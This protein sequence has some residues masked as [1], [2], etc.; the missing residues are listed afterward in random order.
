MR[1][2]PGR[3]DLHILK[4]TNA[5]I[6]QY[7]QVPLILFYCLLT[8]WFP[9]R[10]TLLQSDRQPRYQLCGNQHTTAVCSLHHCTATAA[11]RPVLTQR[12]QLIARPCISRVDDIPL[13]GVPVSQP[14]AVCQRTVADGTRAEAVQTRCGEPRGQPGRGRGVAR[15]QLGVVH[16]CVRVCRR[17]READTKL[18]KKHIHNG[19][20]TVS[21]NIT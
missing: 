16:Q 6:C 18:K 14:D 9:A 4:F 20:V 17:E 12:H 8:Q 19:T 5:F 7:M 2:I 21:L 3:T 10:Q 15:E 11:P 1:H 13:P